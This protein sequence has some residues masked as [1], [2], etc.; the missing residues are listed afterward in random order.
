M[1]IDHDVMYGGGQDDITHSGCMTGGGG[2]E[3]CGIRGVI[4]LEGYIS[5]KS[6]IKTLNFIIGNSNS[7]VLNSLGQIT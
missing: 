6:N 4:Y 1:L 3:S 2:S 5:F 7:T